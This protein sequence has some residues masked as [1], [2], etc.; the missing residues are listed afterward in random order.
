MSQVLPWVAWLGMGQLVDDAGLHQRPD[1]D[2]QP[3]EEQQRLPL[4]AGQVVV[5][6]QAGNDDQ[7]PGAGHRDQ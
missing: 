3:R 2:E 4:H 6:V 1:H 7:D 5:T